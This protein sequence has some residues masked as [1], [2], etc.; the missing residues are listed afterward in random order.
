MSLPS[1]KNS[2]RKA[3]LQSRKL[4]SR[5]EIEARSMAAQNLLI[6][7]P[8]YRQVKTLALYSPIHNEVETAGLLSAARAAGKQVCYPRVFND[9]LRFFQVDSLAD[10]KVG[11]FGV[12]EPHSCLAEIF[13]AKIELMLVPGVAFDLHG[14]RLGYGRGYFDRLL[15]DS[16]FD[17]LSVGFGFDFQIQDKLPTE[18]HDQQLEL[19]VTDKKVY[20]PS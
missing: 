20:S 12:S 11:S 16:C 9:G 17:G 13:P 7:L 5:A 10:L 1:D 19:L 18:E 3:L 6:G 14:H 4:L 8:A 15:H 2:I